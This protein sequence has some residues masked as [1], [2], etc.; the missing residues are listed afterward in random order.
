MNLPVAFTTARCVAREFVRAL[1]VPL[2]LAGFLCRRRHWQQVATTTLAAAATH[3]PKAALARFAARCPRPHG[4]PHVFVSCGEASGELHAERLVRAVASTAPDLRWTC[5][6][7]QRLAQAG[8]ELLWPLAEH[9]VFGLRGALRRLPFFIRAFARFERLLREDRPDLV[10]LVD[11]PGLHLVMAAAARRH[12]I[13]VLHYIAPQYWAWAPW[14]MARYRRAVDATLTILPF[15][16]A[17]FARFGIPSAYVGHPLLDQIE[18]DRPPAPAATAATE[19]PTLVLLPG[20]RTKEIDRHLPGMLQAAARMRATH[21]GLRVVI[22]HRDPR[23]A[24]WIREFLR[25]QDAAGASVHEGSLAAPLATARVVIAKS[26]TGSLEAVLRGVPTVVA[27]QVSGG[28]AERLYSRLLMLPFFASANLIA[29]RAAVPEVAF[30]SAAGWEI[31][32][33]RAAELLAEGPVRTRCLQDLAEVRAR[34]GPAGASAR[35]A[36]WVLAG[37]GR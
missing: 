30:A 18:T 5:F 4:R 9:A 31:V 20:S 3:D 10:V 6:G 22:A 1:A 32:A 11:Y 36:R 15:E 26:G 35:A 19:P 13:P 25:R 34:L 14:R 16:P 24:A 37:V 33:A 21:P 29:C 8:P 2:H 7:G 27:Y 23:Q 17:F 12:G 28:L